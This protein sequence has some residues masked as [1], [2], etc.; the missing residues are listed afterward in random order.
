MKKEIQKDIPTRKGSLILLFLTMV[1]I[2]IYAYLSD[3][4]SRLDLYEFIPLEI[5]KIEIVDK[6]VGVD[7]LNAFYLIDGQVVKLENGA[8]PEFGIVRSPLIV[9]LD[10]DGVNDDAILVLGKGLEGKHSY[11]ITAAIK[12]FYGYKGVNAVLIK[13]ALTVDKVSYT[14]KRI[15]VDYSLGKRKEAAYFQLVDNQLKGVE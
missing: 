4:Q 6:K 8:S 10:E 14:D 2:I 7:P 15:K 13:D 5:P 12:Y 1:V 11:Y 9:D 3:S